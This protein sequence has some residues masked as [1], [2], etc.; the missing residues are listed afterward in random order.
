M[1]SLE[2]AVA[3]QRRI[4]AELGT[5]PGVRDERSLVGVLGR[6][7]ATDR[8]VPR[9]P[10]LFNKVAVLM[11]GVIQEKPFADVNHQ[12]AWAMAASVLDEAGYTIEAPDAD[13]AQ[14]IKGVEMGFTTWHRLTVW[15]KRHARRKSPRGP[16]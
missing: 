15:I 7:L 9:Y 11:I 8:G 12:V 10:T 5:E 6:P 1:I 4:A 14:M 2:H 13:V 3:L 16:Q